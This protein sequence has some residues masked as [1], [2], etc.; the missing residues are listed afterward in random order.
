[1][2]S[3]YTKDTVFTHNALGGRGDSIFLLFS[4]IHLPPSPS[5]SSSLPAW[6]KK[7]SVSHHPL[8]HL[9]ISSNSCL[10]IRL[11][12]AQEDKK[13]LGKYSICPYFCCCCWGREREKTRVRETKRERDIE[14]DRERE[15]ER[16]SEDEGVGLSNS[17]HR[18]ED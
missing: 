5:S 16:E 11:F 18:G 6:V 7:D 14:R 2:W 15:R 1:M 17:L 10:V 13:T 4:V 8:R 3:N 9:S 12:H